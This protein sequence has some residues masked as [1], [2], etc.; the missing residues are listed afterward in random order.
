MATC[1]S[2]R[3]WPCA[4]GREVAVKG[5]LQS[6]T[7][8]SREG[9]RDPKA[10]AHRHRVVRV[11][12]YT[13]VLG[14]LDVEIADTSMVRER[15]FRDMTPVDC[16]WILQRVVHVENFAFLAGV[17]PICPHH[18]NF[19][20]GRTPRARVDGRATA[21]HLHGMIERAVRCHTV[22]VSAESA[23]A[24]GVASNVFL[25]SLTCDNPTKSPTRTT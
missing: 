7:P 13:I 1:R 16:F 17:W 22:K 4:L 8:Y 10:A 18:R 15:Y 6:T 3:A 12:G 23:G 25:R 9:E 14:Q 24:V 20:R 5:S 21:R 11:L 2:R 19:A